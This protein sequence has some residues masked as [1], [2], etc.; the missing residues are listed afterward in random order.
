MHDPNK[1]F[2][3]FSWV[4]GVFKQHLDMEEV[5]VNICWVSKNMTLSFKNAAN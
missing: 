5:T 2:V 3:L 1:I 4:N